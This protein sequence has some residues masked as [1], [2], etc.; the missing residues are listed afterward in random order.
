MLRLKHVCSIRTGEVL[1]V[2]RIHASLREPG[3]DTD[4]AMLRQGGSNRI[5]ND[6]SS[7]GRV[8]WWLLVFP[9]FAACAALW[10]V[11][12]KKKRMPATSGIKQARHRNFFA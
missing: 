3:S 5:I 10:M 12:A 7:S 11:A 6:E 2:V 8:H 4:D 9:A 1:N